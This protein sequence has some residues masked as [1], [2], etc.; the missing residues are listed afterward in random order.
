MKNNSQM[1]SPA[2]NFVLQNCRI[3]N[4]GAITDGDIR[5]CNG[6]I[7]KIGGAI[8]AT[9]NEKII[10]AKE[11]LLF[12]GLIDDQVHFREPG[13]AHKG[14]IASESRAAAA[15]GITSY[16][17]MPN[18]IPPT[19]T[20]EKIAEKRR[21]AAKNSRVNFAF[22]LGAAKNN[23]S[24]IAAADPS[25]IAGVKIFMGSSTG[26]MLV[27]DEKILAEIFSC[28]TDINCNALRIDSA[29]S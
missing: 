25:Q 18:V 10:N 14:D 23:I 8:S 20:M 17:E 13:L 5:V 12:P 1:K 3:V 16:M 2:A 24:D 9:Q 26:D 7:A 21:I 27:D 6:R 29:H 4:E 28:R 19:L 11:R 22:Y 15:G